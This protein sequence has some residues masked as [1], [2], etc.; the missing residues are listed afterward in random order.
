MNMK[1]L[2]VLIVAQSLATTGFAQ[3]ITGTVA[4]RVT[5]STGATVADVAVTLLNIG[6]GL[7]LQ[8]RTADPGDF[9]FPLLRPGRYQLDAER[10]GFHRFE[11]EIFNLAVDETRRIDFSL[12]VGNVS[13]SVVVKER[14]ALVDSDTS[15]LGTVIET[16]EVEELP[17]NG[18]NPLGL[19]QFAPGIQPMGGVSG[20]PPLF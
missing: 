20:L 3:N 13:Q 14:P 9:V 18:R 19:A 2:C 8:A 16:R 5:D 6:T 10:V 17:L 4:G 11:T 12:A 15:S 1:T 7:K